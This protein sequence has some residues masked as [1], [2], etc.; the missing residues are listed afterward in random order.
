MLP[1]KNTKCD[2]RSQLLHLLSDLIELGRAADTM[3]LVQHESLLVRLKVRNG[4]IGAAQSQFPAARIGGDRRVV[5]H[6]RPLLGNTTE[7]P[8]GCDRFADGLGKTV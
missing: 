7:S 1:R 3:K 2:G 8:I 6:V 5:L 4:W